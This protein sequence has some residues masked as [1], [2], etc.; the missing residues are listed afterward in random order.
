MNLSD[1]WNAPRKFEFKYPK[2]MERK[3]KTK[4]T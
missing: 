3:K 2:Q 4:Q 1:I